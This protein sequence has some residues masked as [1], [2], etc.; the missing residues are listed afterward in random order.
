[1]VLSKQLELGFRTYFRAISFIFSNNLWWAFLFPVAIN[2][3]LFLGGYTIIESYT[4]NLQNWVTDKIG[5][6]GANFFL[7]EFV[8]ATI[9]ILLKVLFFFLFAFYGGYITLVLLSPLFAY[10]SERTEEI[11]SGEKY[12]FDFSQF[13]RDIVRGIFIAFRNLFLETIWM[14]LLFIFAFIP[15]IGWLGAIPLFVISA[16]F[17]GFSFIDYTSER[18]KMKIGQ[19]IEFVRIHKWLAIANGIMFSLFLLIPFCGVLLSGFVA[20]VSVVAATLAVNE[21]AP[22]SK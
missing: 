18:R 2:V 22:V 9:W 4:I 13:V 1:M 3:L 10:I 8:G 5:I 7:S 12:P 16:Y 21:I 20:I 15:I 19:S 11:I 17:Y 14:I 6:D